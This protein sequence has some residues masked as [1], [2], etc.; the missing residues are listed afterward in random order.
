VNDLV[1]FLR[2]RYDDDASWALACT[3][4]TGE[5]PQPFRADHRKVFGGGDVV[6]E[7]R[8][9]TLAEHI[10][11]HDPARVLREVE[12]KR[13]ILERYRALVEDFDHVDETVFEHTRRATLED[14][15][16][17]LALPYADHPDYRE[18]W[19]S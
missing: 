8:S 18:E 7:T 17:D 19:K 15:L 1:E 4:K 16:A 5:M 6:A 9:A 13:R 10:A 12:A 2:A 3:H 11:R 14:A